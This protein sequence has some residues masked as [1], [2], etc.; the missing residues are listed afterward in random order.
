MQFNPSFGY[1][2]N[3]SPILQERF[4]PFVGQGMMHELFDDGEGNGGHIGPDE[5][6]VQHMQGV[7]HA[8]R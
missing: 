1:F 7:A 8:G 5:R 6:P 3:A 4:K 2:A